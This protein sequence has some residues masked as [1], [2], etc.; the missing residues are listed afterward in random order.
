MSGY[1]KK[2]ELS[3]GNVKGKVRFQVNRYYAPMIYLEWTMKA[4]YILWVELMISLKPGG[5]G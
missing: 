1:W 3:E 5:E 4:S 2:P